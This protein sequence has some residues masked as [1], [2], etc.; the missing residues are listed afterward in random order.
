MDFPFNDHASRK[1]SWHVSKYL[2][3]KKRQIQ[4]IIFSSFNDKYLH[5]SKHKYIEILKK[6]YSY[7]GGYTYC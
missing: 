6:H 4:S 1:L 2:H 3:P 5:V 7:C